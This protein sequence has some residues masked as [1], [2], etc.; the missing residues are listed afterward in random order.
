M[1]KRYELELHI[2]NVER[3]KCQVPKGPLQAEV[4]NGT[5]A[6]PPFV[7]ASTFSLELGTRMYIRY[8]SGKS[9]RVGGEPCPHCSL[10]E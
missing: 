7:A 6:V 8:T 2:L 9:N 3:A 1:A 10:E 4:S 5:I